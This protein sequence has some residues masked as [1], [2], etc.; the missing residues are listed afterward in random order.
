MIYR[1]APIDAG[2][3]VR[4]P[5]TVNDSA[6][7]LRDRKRCEGLVP[8]NT[9]HCDPYTGARACV[10]VNG[11]YTDWSDIRRGVRQGCV[12]SPRLFNLYMDSCL[13]D[14]KEYEYGLRTDELINAVRCDCVVCSSER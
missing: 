8:A 14:L 13:Y 4:E 12:A 2:S 1:S 5:A 10:T 7:R 11:A 6:S 3:I 9:G